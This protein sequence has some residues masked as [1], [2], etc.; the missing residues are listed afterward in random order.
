MSKQSPILLIDGAPLTTQAVLEVARFGRQVRLTPTALEKLAEGRRIVDEVVAQGRVTYG[1]NTGFGSLSR[2]TIPADDVRQVQRNLIRSHSAGIGDPLP[3]EVVRAMMVILLA[4]LSRGHSGVRPVVAETLAAVLNANIVPVVPSRG[5]VGASGD[6]APLSHIVLVLIGEGLAHVDV[7]IMDGEVALEQAGITPIILEAKEGLALINGTHLMS[8]LGSLLIED[9][10]QLLAA[11]LTASAM[12]IDANRATDAFLDARVH[13]IRQQHGQQW[14]AANM[15]DL[16]DGSTILPSHI[17]DDPRVQD[18]YSFRC[19]PQVLGAVKDTLDHIHTVIER[20]LG[21]VTDNPLVFP[22]NGAII[23]AG[24]FHGM[25]LAIVLDMLTIALTHMAGISERRVYHL[26]SASDSENP[27]NAYL[28]PQPGLHS[29]LMI[30]QYTA[31]AA[32]NELQTLCAPASVH[33]VPTSAGMEDYNSFGPTAGHQ[34]WRALD[35]ARHVIA[36]EFLCAAEALEYQRPLHS[37]TQV[38]A[39]YTT[40]RAHIPRL[41]EDRSPAPDFAKIVQVIRA[42]QL[43]LQ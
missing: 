27:L 20:E 4:S 36:I 3:N 21:A 26:L 13:E 24:N 18:P 10:E 25:P 37:G 38:E 39:A 19:T 34:A 31:A 30:A 5:S 33:N 40:I 43:G 29:G 35:L 15:R 8:A 23:S 32:C 41:T 1:V 22:D 16:L 17:T 12:M 6:L 2:V 14:V 7:E 28:S 9:A 42:G 11:A